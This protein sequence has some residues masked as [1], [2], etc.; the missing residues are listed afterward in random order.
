[1]RPRY[2]GKPHAALQRVTFPRVTL[3]RRTT[4]AK[5]TAVVRCAP[6]KM[7][8]CWPA[9]STSTI[10]ELGCITPISNILPLCGSSLICRVAVSMPQWGTINGRQYCVFGASR[11]FRLTLCVCLLHYSVWRIP[12]FKKL[13]FGLMLA[14]GIATTS[15]AIAAFNATSSAL[16]PAACTCCGEACIC[17]VCDC[18]AESCTCDAG[19]ECACDAACCATCCEQ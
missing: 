6:P 13:F 2:T 9:Q 17:E 5:V 10:A 15:L 8:S 14:G 19:G 12:M 7:P 18:D 16:P 11:N 4:S 3:Q 1:M